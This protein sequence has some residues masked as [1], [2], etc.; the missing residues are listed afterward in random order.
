MDYVLDYA[1]ATVLTPYVYPAS[2]PADNVLRQFVSLFFITWLGGFVLYFLCSGLSYFLVFDHELM[3]HPK[4]LKNQ[5]RREIMTTLK[6]MPG[7]AVLTALC[8]VGEVRG[9]SRLYDHFDSGWTGVGQLAASTV[10]F[11]LFTD[12]CIYWIHR[13]LHH[14]W[15][16]GPLHKLHHVWKLPTPFASHAFHPVDGFMQSLPYHLYVFIFPLHKG[17]YLLLYVA[18]NVWSTSVH[19]ND[20]RVPHVLRPFINSSAHHTDHHLYFNYN[21]G[22]YFTL[23]DRIGGS[24][25]TPMAYEGAGVHS[26][27]LKLQRGESIPTTP[28]EQEGER[29]TTAAQDTTA[30]GPAKKMK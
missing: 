22:Q 27:M 18:V 8:F 26:D 12:M 29:S 14:P 2:W 23:W 24:F 1:D 20:Y 16:Y 19:D 13:W 11:I 6:G 4:F 30:P 9:H 3:K 28:D 21:Y 25:R 17:L 10:L 5:V 15:F 7:M